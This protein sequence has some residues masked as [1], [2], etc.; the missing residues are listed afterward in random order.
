ME[1]ERYLEHLD[2]AAERLAD[3]ARPDLSRAVP[4]CPGWTVRDAVVHTGAV[5][6]HK[7][8]GMRLQR[9]RLNAGEWPTEPAEGEDPVAW[10]LDAHAALRAELVSRG[11]R[12]PSPTWWPPDQTVGFWYRRMAHEVVIHRVDVESAFDAVTPVD[13]E[14]AADGADEVLTIFLV[15][16]DAKPPER[17]SGQRVAVETDGQRWVVTLAADALDVRR[18][19]EASVDATVTG[20]PSDVDLWL[21]GRGPLDRLSLDGDAGAT[22][23]LREWLVAATQ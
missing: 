6:W 9:Y 19:A 12:A 23:V 5:F 21:W 22:D 15:D 2:T 13:A 4:T 17:A 3:V 1:H 8:M 18:D 11:P 7:T 16:S 14:F 10:F 20:T